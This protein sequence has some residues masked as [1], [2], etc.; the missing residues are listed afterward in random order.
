MTFAHNL[1]VVAILRS[2]EMGQAL[3]EACTD[4]NGTRVDVHVGKLGDVRPGI[5][6]FKNLDV[7]L[8]DVD[9]RDAE[10]V[11]EL[12]R[13]VRDRFPTTPVVATAADATLQ[14]VRQFMRLGVVDFVPQPIARLDLLSA[15]EHA[16]RVHQG[17]AG[18]DTR[19]RVISFLKAGGGAGATTL[20]AQAACSLAARGKSKKA[21]TCLL[22]LDVQ[23]G[24]AALY[25]DLDDRVGLAD[26]L[27]SPERLDAELLRSVMT[28]HEEGIDVLAAPRDMMPLETVTQA[29]VTECFKLVREEYRTALVDLPGPWT[30]WVVQAIR[31]SD[32]VVLVTQLTV[33]GVRQTR[34]QLQTLHDQGLSEVPVKIAVNRFVKKG[35]GKSSHLKEAEK[36]LG[37]KFDYF[38][39]NDYGLVSEAHDRG[40]ALGEVKRKTKVEQSVRALIEDARRS[41]GGQ[42]AHAEPRLGI[43]FGR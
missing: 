4:M 7:L 20:A 10:Q 16:A 21:E 36:A 1:N 43:G 30:P 5:E 39:A 25:L 41:A 6:I 18:E 38:V 22:D 40:V 2:R 12:Q 42:A 28:V 19:G 34:R 32:L 31:A 23:F 15:L 33:A 27:E 13:V 9:P 37:R 29:F 26:L 14:D 8:L 3:N 17:S 11:N 35:W 24:T